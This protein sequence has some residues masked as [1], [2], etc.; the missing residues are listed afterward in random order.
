MHGREGLRRYPTG[1]Y[2][3]KVNNGNTRSFC[4]ICS[5]LTIKTPEQCLYCG[6]DANPSFPN[7]S[8]LSLSYIFVCY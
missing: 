1:I 2:L 5:K 7:L 4:E 3:L 6:T 8:L